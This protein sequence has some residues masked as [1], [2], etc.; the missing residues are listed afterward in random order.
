MVALIVGVTFIENAREDA[1]ETIP[2]VIAAYIAYCL[3]RLQETL[4]K[5]EI[6]RIS[7][8]DLIEFSSFK[9]LLQSAMNL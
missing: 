6:M 5:I 8:Q 7:R 2:T 9:E 1:V 4:A 3:S